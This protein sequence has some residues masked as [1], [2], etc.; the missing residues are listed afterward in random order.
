[1]KNF[2]TDGL[3]LHRE[4]FDSVL[5]DSGAFSAMSVGKTVNIDEY[6]QFAKDNRE[7]YNLIAQLD[8]IGDQ[9]KTLK[10]YLYMVKKG[11]DWAMPILTGEWDI[12]LRKMEKHALTNYYGVGGKSF[13]DKIY[14]SRWDVVKSLPSKNDYHG[15]AKGKY[16]A[17]KNGWFTSID[18]STW[19]FGARA[20]QSVARLKGQNLLVNFGNRGLHNRNDIRY[21]HSLLRDEFEAC[22]VNIDDVVAGEYNALLKIAIPIYYRPLFKE[23]GHR[24]FE[25][26]FNF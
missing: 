17:L 3:K 18:S 10:N 20:R 5:I 14:K 21:T 24:M 9:D 8:E 11:V 2:K 13:W 26:N 6:C 15:F 19:S 16:E 23:I 7:Y 4:Y 22:K 1:M 12:A 25:D